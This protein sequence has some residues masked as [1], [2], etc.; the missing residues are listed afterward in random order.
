M[1]T[2]LRPCVGNCIN[3]IWYMYSFLLDGGGGGD[4][5]LFSM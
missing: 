2:S 3:I 4:A 5:T 1:F